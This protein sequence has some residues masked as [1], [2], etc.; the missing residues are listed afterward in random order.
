MKNFQQFLESA[1]EGVIA[2]KH[3][4]GQIESIIEEKQ[5]RI[6]SLVE[7]KDKLFK[8]L[9]QI[10]TELERALKDKSKLNDAVY[11]SIN[12]ARG[13]TPYSTDYGSK[14]QLDSQLPDSDKTL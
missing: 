3:H 11:S 13:L 6:A 5:R 12:I 9:A 14:Y 8:A 7:E 2:H 1:P 4:L 10:K